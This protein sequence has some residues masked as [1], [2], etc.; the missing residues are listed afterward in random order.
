MADD[1]LIAALQKP[2]CFDHPI[3]RFQLIETHLSWVIL[4]GPFAY[5]I[6]RPVDF[7]FV[8][9]TSLE[10]RY[11]YC[12]EEI[13][14]NQFLA[15]QIY[16]GVVAITGTPDK[17]CING[18]GPIIDYAV[19]MTEFNQA[20]LL[21]NLAKETGITEKMVITIADDMAKFHLQ[22]ATSHEA[23]PYATPENV[24]APVQ[25][26]FDQILPLLTEQSDI[27]NINQIEAWAKNEYN[28]LHDIFA[29][30]KKNGCVRECH[31][32]IHLGNIVSIDNQPVIFDCIEFNEYFRWIDVMAE[33]GFIAMDLENHGYPELS[34]AI[35]NRYLQR[36]GDYHGLN[37]LTFYQS[38]RAV[39]RAKITLF[40]LQQP[41]LTAI[42][43]ERL[44]KRYQSCIQLALNYTK[45]RSPW[46][47]ITFGVSCSGKS[48]VSHLISKQM[49]A[50]QLRS[51]IERKRIYGFAFDEQT[52]PELKEKIYS[53][54]AHHRT[55]DRVA[56]LADNAIQAGYP[57][58]AD[59]T[60]SGTEFRQQ[61]AALATKLNVPF[62]I[63]HTHAPEG[64]L[65]QWIVERQAQ[66]K[67]P[68]EAT[69]SVLENQLKHLT[70][71]NTTEQKRTIDIN[72]SE[73]KNTGE[74]DWVIGAINKL[75]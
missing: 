58:I 65:K 3:T 17:P 18:D 9:Y 24:Q 13:R 75:L 19:K 60:F 47:M 51:D 56:E 70:P 23:L 10:K 53:D 30:R 50:I 45:K 32:D 61:F 43:I 29:W 54:K 31:G 38:Y 25:Q 14:L 72:T 22:S 34:N 8:D 59:A 40:H 44:K 42:E 52:S 27:D 62:V 46:L 4:T 7:E 2:E 11:H 16:L 57:V 73:Y 37:V 67:D 63:L 28:R 71:L 39:V 5:K 35:V 15:P 55:Y 48:T 6:K 74:L 64:E 36:T 41:N 1:N 69:L 26:N 12:Q 33:L 68:S 49:N 21:N 66:N 20:G